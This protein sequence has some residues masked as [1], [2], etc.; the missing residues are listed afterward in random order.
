M[1]IDLQAFKQFEH[2]GWMRV[3]HK[4]DATWSSLTGKFIA[5][6]LET[7]G[8][9]KGM[10]ILDVACGPGYVA[11][12]A[13]RLGAAPLGID[14]CREMV[15]Q[16]QRRNPGIEFL[17]GNAEDLQLT[18]E[19]FDCVVMNFG[20]LHLA[21]PEK[22]FAEARRVLRRGGKYGFTLWAKPEHNI[23]EKIMH[24]AFAAHGDATAA[25][26]EGPPIFLFSEREECQQT[27]HAAGF[28]PDSITFETLGVEWE[29][30]T[31]EF[32]F[33][34]KLHAGVRSSAVLARQAPER[35]QAIRAAVETSVKR[36]AN[37]RGYDIP[38]AAHLISA[39]AA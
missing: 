21:H 25:L 30:P 3:A 13:Q 10:R 27:L 5:P 32:L 17:E 20:V 8:V 1:A 7:A 36:Y 39:V 12:A 24:E 26:P 33:E 4:Y 9:K 11:A 29:V 14:F 15:E 19:N 37:G 38:V 23:S 34:A 18:S 35:L 31:A 22:A 28:A 16:A 6:L 2:D